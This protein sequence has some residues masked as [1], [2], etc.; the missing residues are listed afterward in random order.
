MFAVEFK[1]DSDKDEFEFL[2]EL[3]QN[4]VES[5]IQ[6]KLNGRIHTKNVFEKDLDFALNGKK[7]VKSIQNRLECYANYI[8]R[9]KKNSNSKHY[10]GHDNRSYMKTN[11]KQFY[12]KFI[13]ISQSF[14]I[15]I[16][17]VTPR[18]PNGQRKPINLFTANFNKIVKA[19]IKIRSFIFWF[20][21][22]NEDLK[23]SQAYY[24]NQ[25]LPLM[26]CKSYQGYNIGEDYA[27]FDT[28]LVKNTYSSKFTV[29]II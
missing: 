17:V 24:D 19:G 14:G 21:I 28:D 1:I 10:Q 22:P 9:N 3:D 20:N 23:I 16:E 2:R 27:N 4:M 8:M 12:I 18:T 13:N 26:Q 29:F 6:F 5:H 15:K 11:K 7:I 25:K